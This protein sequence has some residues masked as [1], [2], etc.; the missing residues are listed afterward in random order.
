MHLQLDESDFISVRDLYKKIKEVLS[1]PNTERKFDITDNQLLELHDFLDEAFEM[2]LT[3]NDVTEKVF[4]DA[5][6]NKTGRKRT[7]QLYFNF[8]EIQNIEKQ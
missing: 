1:Q 5:T 2:L 8:N 4:N 6:A 7:K 3:N